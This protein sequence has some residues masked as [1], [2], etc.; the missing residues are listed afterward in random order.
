M[1]ISNINMNRYNI[2]CSQPSLHYSEYRYDVL[3]NSEI[4]DI[5]NNNIINSQLFKTLQKKEEKRYEMELNIILKKS[6]SNSKLELMKIYITQ[7]RDKQSSLLIQI[8]NPND[9]LFLYILELSEIEYQQFK[10]EQGLLVDY[11]KF[12]DY[13]LEMLSKCKNDKEGKYICILNISEG[14]ENNMNDSAPAILAIEEKTQYKKLNNLVLKLQPANDNNLKKYLSNIYKEYKDKYESLLEKDNELKQNLDILE[15]ENNILKEKIQNLE[16]N[17]KTSMNNY[18]NQKNKEIN[19]IKEKSLIESNNK[20]QF[21]EKSKNKIINELEYKITQLQ[22]TIDNMTIN[23]RQSEEKILKLEARIKELEGKYAITNTELNVYKTEIGNLRYENTELNQKYLIY[24]KQIT[25]FNFKNESL[26]SQLDEKNKSTENMKQLIDTLNRQRDSNED[27]IKSLKINNSK[28]D[29]KLQLSISEIKKANDII[30]KLQNEI[31]NQKI[32]IKSMKNELN[33]KDQ[34]ISQKQIILDEQ[35]RTI[36]EIKRENEKKEEEKNGLTIQL[37]SYKDKLNEDEK[38]IEENNQMIQYLNKNL[39]DNL[40]SPFMSRFNYT[41]MNNN[42]ISNNN[43][44]GFDSNRM[45]NDNDDKEYYSS[46]KSNNNNFHN[47]LGGSNDNDNDNYFI[48]PETNFTG[49]QFKGRGDTYSNKYNRN[50]MKLTQG[51]DKSL[52]IHKY[53]NTYN[54]KNDRNNINIQNRMNIN[55]SNKSNSGE[56]YSKDSLNKEENADKEEF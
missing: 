14:E 51:N 31:K 32:I 45:K 2:N 13:L 38:I 48:M 20:L 52:L 1:S 33:T 55:E 46:I 29:N 36:S 42:N 15:K 17:N 27:I 19:D 41:G 43:Y 49:F 8:T 5:N 35:S 53:G 54:Q 12:P 28:L 16:I 25:E 22:K 37:N 50:N 4:N 39:N 6:E 44:F 21:V 9:S 40:N 30:Q 18:I 47:S 23:N 11:Q 3:N 34:L 10:L 7:K 26:K 24:E 56:V